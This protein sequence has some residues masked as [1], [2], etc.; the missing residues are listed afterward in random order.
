VYEIATGHSRSLTQSAATSFA[1]PDARALGWSSDSRTLLLSDGWDVWSFAAA[2]GR[3]V[4]LTVNGRR[5][6]IRYG[7][8]LFRRD[9]TSGLD[10]R[11]PFFVRAT[12]AWTKRE[13]I[14]RID[15]GKPGA[16]LWLWDDAKVDIRKAADADMWIYTR[17]TATEFP[18]Y[19]AASAAMSSGVR[20][21][22]ANPQQSEF[23]WTAGASLLDYRTPDGAR[24]QAALHLPA[25]YEKGRTWPT[26]VVLGDSGSRALHSH[27]PPSFAPGLSYSIYTNRGFAVLSPDIRHTPNEPGKAALESVAAA[28]DAG[29]AAGVV[30][31]NRVG[32]AGHGWGA[33]QVSF[34]VTQS[35]AFAAA[36]ATAPMTNLVNMFGTLFWRDAAPESL[37]RMVLPWFTNEFWD[38]SAVYVRNSPVFQAAGVST[39]LLLQHNRGDSVVDFNQSLDFSNTLRRLNRPVELLEYEGEGHTLSKQANRVAFSIRMREFL[40]HFVVGRAGRE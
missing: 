31:S 2:G 9:T 36:V 34:I 37:K 12:G 21:T 13:G 7:E 5:D 25:G 16:A 8:V 4:N 38:S 33:Y 6:S 24:L 15:A 18:D 23:A 20:I 14:A 32:L 28:L 22:R 29:V 40:E 3:A 1:G 11:R 39:P 19:Y 10:L 30:D 27:S 17:Q 26:I 35:N